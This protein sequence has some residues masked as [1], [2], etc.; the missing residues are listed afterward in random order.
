[1]NYLSDIG[2]STPMP[3]V[4]VATKTLKLSL[5]LNNCRIFSLWP[6]SVTLVNISTNQNSGKPGAAVGMVNI[7][8]RWLLKK[9]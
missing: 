4:M 3:N 8:Q 1:M 6:L 2:Q 9:E 5:E 7:S